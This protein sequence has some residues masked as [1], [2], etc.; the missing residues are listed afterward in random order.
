MGRRGG[1]GRLHGKMIIVNGVLPCFRGFEYSADGERPHGSVR[2]RTR[3]GNPKAAS[4][5]AD[6]LEGIIERRGGHRH[7]LPERRPL[8]RRGGQVAPHAHT[9]AQASPRPRCM[10]PAVISHCNPN[11]ICAPPPRLPLLLLQSPPHPT[12]HP[13]TQIK[14]RLNPPNLPPP[15]QSPQTYTTL[16]NHTP[17]IPTLLPNSPHAEVERTTNTRN[18][19]SI[20]CAL[21]ARR[22]H[23]SD[24]RS[25]AVAAAACTRQMERG[26]GYQAGRQR[27]RARAD[28]GQRRRSRVRRHVPNGP[29]RAQM[30]EWGKRDST[31]A[32]RGGA[33]PGGLR[34]WWAWGDDGAR[35]WKGREIFGFHSCVP[36]QARGQMAA[37]AGVA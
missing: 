36:S 16:H 3:D 14:T 34:L 26:K 9:A 28:C 19:C 20:G 11:V 33:G 12:P 17:K 30:R 15:P 8:R 32:A 21:H 2:Q 27:E 31:V 4:A 37:S 29:E 23:G 22:E 25:A 1:L 10:T 5:I 24:I 13:R 6:R 35:V 18:S 7:R